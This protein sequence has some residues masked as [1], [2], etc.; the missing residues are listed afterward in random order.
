MLLRPKLTKEKASPTSF[1]NPE[2]FE[3]LYDHYWEKVY[4]VCY[5]HTGNADLSQ[6]MTQDIFTSVWERR[7]S[8]RVEKSIEHYLVRSAKMKVFEYFRNQ[9]I[10][11][12]HTEAIAQIQ[13]TTVADTDGKVVHA[14]LSQEINV[15]V[16]RLSERCRRVFLLSREQGL[17]NKQIAQ[18][19]DVS[20]RAVQ[21]HIS[22]AVDK[23]K[24][25][26]K[27]DG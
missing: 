20:E 4:A 8:L 24:Q 23:L 19:L 27:A 2:A 13:P 25:N 5:H 21:Q 6:D 15:W 12:K 1:D 26:L 22:H 10:R 11:E 17:S 18:K 16:N 7:N 3:A 14:L 9:T